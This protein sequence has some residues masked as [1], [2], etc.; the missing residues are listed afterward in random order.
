MATPD[1]VQ[2]RM[3]AARAVEETL[4]FLAGRWKLM[5]LFQ[6]FG[7]EVRRFSE[8]RRAIPSMSE[9][10]LS[11]QLRKMEADGLVK[12]IPHQQIPPKVEYRLT[13]WGQSLCPVL[14]ALLRWDALHAAP[15]EGGTAGSASG[16]RAAP[17][18]GP[19]SVVPAGRGAG[20]FRPRRAP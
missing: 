11:Q 5:I 16:L 7:G 6:L 1:G 13:H 20:A 4:K 17:P 18:E 12:R 15:S 10:M 14:D 8:L 3:S 19:S 9:K 2:N